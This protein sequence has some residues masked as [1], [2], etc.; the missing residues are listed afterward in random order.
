M[1]ESAGRGADDRFLSSACP[2]IIAIGNPARGDDAIGP[3][4]ARAAKLSQPKKPDEGVRRDS[5]EP[6]HNLLSTS[7]TPVGQAVSPANLALARSVRE[8]PT[9]DPA[10]LL[11]AFA[12]SPEVILIDAIRSGAPP[13]TIHRFDA[14]AHALP[15]DVFASTHS[16]G[17]AE[18]I[19]LA[20][21]LNRLPRRLTV[22]GI[23]AGDFELGAPLTPAVAAAIDALVA[24]LARIVL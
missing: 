3:L 17:L 5:G 8:L 15:R 19:E 14:T 16:F 10:A 13:G 6:P 23:E 9:P 21:A 11:D 1:R 7:A 20:R 18:A 22:Y 4:V 2:L 12:S 24:E